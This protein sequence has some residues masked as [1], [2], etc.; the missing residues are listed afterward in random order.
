MVYD[1]VQACYGA[2]DIVFQHFFRTSP[3]GTSPTA[4]LETVTPVVR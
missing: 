3:G 4:A 1:P 2:T